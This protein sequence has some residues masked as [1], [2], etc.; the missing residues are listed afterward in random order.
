MTMTSSNPSLINVHRM[1]HETHI[2]HDGED[3]AGISNQRERKRLQNR[4]NQRAR[5]LILTQNA[6]ILDFKV[7]WL[8]CSA[9]SPFNQPGITPVTSCPHTLTPTR[10][11]Q[12]IPH[13]PWIDLF[14]LPRM[15]ENFLVA[16][17]EGLSD[18]EEQRLW[19]DLIES[20][21]ENNWTGFIV[22]GEPWDSKNWERWGWLLQGCNQL[23]E[24]TNY[25]RLQRGEGCISAEAWRSHKRDIVDGSTF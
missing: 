2:R 24:A 18:D 17:C 13:H 12:K 1:P 10:L 4:L 8:L 19:D 23:L 14:P 6:V 3:W 22:W 7:D 21:G 9:T 11:Q 15:R 25:W 16:R 20:H 5:E